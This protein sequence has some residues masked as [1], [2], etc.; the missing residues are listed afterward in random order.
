MANGT[1]SHADEVDDVRLESVV[2]AGCAA[3]PQALAVEEREKAD[4]KA[5]INAAVLGYDIACRVGIALNPI[6]LQK[7]NHSLVTIPLSFGSVAASS[8]I[9]GLNEDQVFSALGLTAQQASGIYASFNEPRHMAK[10][11]ESVAGGRNGV[12]AAL[13]AQLGFQGPP[14]IFEGSHNIS[15]ASQIT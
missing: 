2:H 4:G 15:D 14:D 1:L 7:N 6:L 13:L 12:T 10:A 9:L 3:V 8:S 11:F 5:F